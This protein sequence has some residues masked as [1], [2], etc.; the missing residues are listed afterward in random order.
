MTCLKYVSNKFLF[1]PVNAFHC[2]PLL[3]RSC[4]ELRS[5]DDDSCV[6]TVAIKN[7]NEPANDWTNEGI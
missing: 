7:L 5:T 3:V 6:E 4:I 2:G 1:Q